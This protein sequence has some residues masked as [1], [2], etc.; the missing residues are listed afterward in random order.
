MGNS[1]CVSKNAL[2]GGC[3]DG[4]SHF[5]QFLVIKPKT[6]GWCG[7]VVG[8]SD[9]EFSIGLPK[10]NNDRFKDK[11]LSTERRDY[12]HLYLGKS[13]QTTRHEVLIHSLLDTQCLWGSSSKS[14]LQFI[15]THVAHTAMPAI[16]SRQIF[17][18]ARWRCCFKAMTFYLYKLYYHFL[19]T[20]SFE[21][22]D[23]FKQWDRH[24]WGVR[25][26]KWAMVYGYLECGCVP[27]ET[28]LSEDS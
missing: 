1:F 4:S 16:A 24:Y 26:K 8:Q 27:Q 3:T 20:N 6:W 17:T 21:F 19:G 14:D 2:I 28:K 23:L 13:L 9:Y 5:F 10:K 22:N 25:T 7:C 11:L 18:I 15:M 12:I